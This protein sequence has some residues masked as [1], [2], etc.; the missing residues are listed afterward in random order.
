MP[1][2]NEKIVELQQRFDNLVKYQ[3]YFNGEMAHIQR[4]IQKLRY[5]AQTQTEVKVEK[6]EIPI[7]TQEI[8]IRSQTDS[9]S[10]PSQPVSPP[11]TSQAQPNF[12]APSASAIP[13]TSEIKANLEKFIGEN[14][15]SKIG[16]TILVLGVAIGA[17]YAIDHDLISPLTRIILGYLVG[18][19]LL[20]FAIRLKAKYLN[21]SAVL[22]SGSMAI[23]Y[24]L[25]FAAYSFYGLI[26]QGLAFGLML[27]FTIF[28]VIASINYDRQVIAHIGLVGA[29]T[30]P[31]LLSQDT[32]RYGVLFSYI[33]LIN[34][35]ILAVSIKKYWKPL[36]YSSFIISWLIFFAWY[37]DK[38]KTD[39]HFNLGLT[40]ATIFFLTFYVTFLAY[41]LISKEKFG[42][43]NV[44]LLLA[45]SFIYYGLGYS[46]L[47][48]NASWEN[49]LGLFTVANAFIHFVVGTVIY[50]YTSAEANAVNLIIGLVLVFLTIAI[51]V[52]LDGNWVTLLW[53]GEAALLF[54][55]GR[56]KNSSLFEYFSYPLMF[57]ASFSLLRDWTTA[58]P[59]FGFWESQTI[60]P[61]IFNVIFLTGILFVSAFSLIWYLNKN[62]CALGQ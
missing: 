6:V 10:Q 29:Y 17:K 14:L 43:E 38:Y 1:D 31:F 22:L 44:G 34:L 45:N 39:E 2:S 35:G 54:W 23:M 58:S 19:G 7:Q 57:L 25:T 5:A 13:P 15:I 51:P 55:L 9:T 60:H 21:F 40:F 4:E 18:I 16:I 33:S 53:T 26:P 3:N 48:S 37:A 61:P 47:E 27:F 56:T 62:Y 36:F 8:P 49:Y 41:K 12:Q 42:L 20:G 50:R 28:T 59:L 46:M 11:Q 30:I 32:G 24:F 52:Q